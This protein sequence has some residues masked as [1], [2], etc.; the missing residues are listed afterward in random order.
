MTLL[1]EVTAF[2]REYINHPTQRSEERNSKIRAVYKT[3]TGESVS[4]CRT[5][6]LEALLIINKRNEMGPCKYL[7]KEGARLVAFGD[8]SKNCTNRNITNELAEW[9]LSHNPTCA[10]LFARMP[11]SILPGPIVAKVIPSIES[12]ES[13]EIT[14]DEEPELHS[15][16]AALVEKAK[17]KYP[18]RKNKK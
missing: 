2:S 18:S 14:K 4:S 8:Y 7:L 5:C 9:H 12:V 3:L 15:E 6:L 16:P 13:T 11:E 1:E 17:R 10:R